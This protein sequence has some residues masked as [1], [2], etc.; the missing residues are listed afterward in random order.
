LSSDLS[1][2]A[3]DTTSQLDVLWHDGDSLRVD[4]AQVGVFEQSNQISFAGFL[5]G[6]N[7]GALETQISLE[8]LGDLTDQTLEGQFADQQFS[9]FLVAT[10]FTKSHYARTI[11]MWFLDSTNGWSTF[12]GWGGF[13]ELPQVSRVQQLFTEQLSLLGRLFYLMQVSWVQR[14]F[15]EQLKKSPKLRKVTRDWI[16]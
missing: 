4:G 2:F 3:S 14:L 5:Q 8:I 10:N 9:R 15:L 11:T 12:T 16:V 13:F 7:S 1:A 6:Y